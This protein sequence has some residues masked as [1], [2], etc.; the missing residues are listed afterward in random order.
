[1]LCKPWSQNL[2]Y[3]LYLLE[4]LHILR[5]LSVVSFYLDF[6]PKF[7]NANTWSMVYMVPFKKFQVNHFA[8]NN[9][10]LYIQISQLKKLSIYEKDPCM[11]LV[12]RC[13]Q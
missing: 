11:P 10:V 13:I 7:L 2:G 6:G 8:F 5:V 1:M 4:Y 9:L 12:Q 3:F